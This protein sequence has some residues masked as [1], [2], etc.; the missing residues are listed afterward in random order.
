MATANSVA[1]EILCCHEIKSS[2][3]TI[4]NWMEQAP[5]GW[6]FVEKFR[7][8]LASGQAKVQQ[9]TPEIV[10][11]NTA[12]GTPIDLAEG[13]F[14]YDGSV[15]TIYID[16]NQELGQLLPTLFHE[17]VHAL[18]PEYLKSFWKV[19][20]ARQSFKK[21]TLDILEVTSARVHKA[22]SDLIGSD[23]TLNEFATLQ[24]ERQTYEKLRQARL[25]AAERKA[26]VFQFQFV[27]EMSELFPQ[28]KVYCQELSRNGFSVDV[29]MTDEEICARYG[30][31]PAC[32]SQT[33]NT[34]TTFDKM[35]DPFRDAA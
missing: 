8:L 2:L 17:M 12:Q 21:K 10:K 30:L 29:S 32:L 1:P 25:F 3:E 13:M 18:D 7:P 19:E 35:S 31:D 5:T 9:I 20:H 4:L 33:A 26:Y 14:V 27:K 11:E 34:L 23:C 28:F 6:R 24:T 22:I 16:F 15:R